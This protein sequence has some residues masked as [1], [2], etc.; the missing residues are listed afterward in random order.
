MAQASLPIPPFPADTDREAFGHWLSGFCD[1][2]AHFQLIVVGPTRSR[3]DSRATPAARF[4]IGLRADDL[5]VLQLIRAYL[6]CGHVTL[7]AG[8]V[9]RHTGYHGHDSYKF[10]VSRTSDV[11]STLVPHFEH[12]PLR[13]KKL[14]DFIVWREG[15]RL[16]QEA[17]KSPHHPRRRLRWTE[18]RISRF[19]S[20]IAALRAGRKFNAPEAL[21]TPPA[22]GGEPSL[23][24]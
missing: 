2:E 1:G 19:R 14:A 8:N 23:F 13:A 10:E 16:I 9:I 4:S 5:P 15:V 17:R 11:V 22:P 21:G 12:Y 18:E 7:K 24:D 6:R 3:P 20:L